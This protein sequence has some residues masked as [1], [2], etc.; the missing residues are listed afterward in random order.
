MRQASRRGRRRGQGGPC[1]PIVSRE[2]TPF[3]RF[4]SRF[5]PKVPEKSDKKARIVLD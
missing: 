1:R 3:T 2:S 5:D 4:L